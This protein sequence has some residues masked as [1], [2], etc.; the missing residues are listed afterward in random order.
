MMRVGSSLRSTGGY[1]MM[2]SV[3]LSFAS[4]LLRRLQQSA[5]GQYRATE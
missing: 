4:C 3:P 1:W 2:S 5:T